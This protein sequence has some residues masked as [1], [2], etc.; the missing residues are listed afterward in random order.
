[1]REVPRDDVNGHPKRLAQGVVQSVARDRDGGSFDF[2]GEACEVFEGPC[3]VAN[4]RECFSE[5]LAVVVRFNHGE[6]LCTGVGCLSHF[7]ED[8]PTLSRV[9]CFP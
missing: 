8:T 2:V 5:G 1:M 9:H 6:G 4:F 3:S 7:V